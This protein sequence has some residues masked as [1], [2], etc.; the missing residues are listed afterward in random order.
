[1]SLYNQIGIDYDVTRRADPYIVGRLVHHLQTEP[2]GKYLD[3]ACGTGNYTVAIAN[4][5]VDIDGIDQSNLM[6]QT[7]RQKSSQI[8]WH[9]GSAES[10]PFAD[11]T[12]SGALCTLAIHHFSALPPVFREVFRVLESGRFVLFTA[13][14]QQMAGCW[15][16]EYFP[17]ALACSIEQMPDLEPVIHSLQE[18]GFQ[19][20]YTEPY[21]VTNELQDFFFYSGKHRPEIYLDP[22]IR[23]GLSTF[24]S[25]AEPD[26]VDSGCRRLAL[27]IQSGK[28]EDIMRSY[29]HN[30]GD[31]LFIVAEKKPTKA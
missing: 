13:T 1:M 28:I 4:S 18:V 5:G 25:L 30:Q 15:L 9:I 17:K 7:A 3:V 27:D 29:S 6:I 11:R 14:H 21:E 10:L 24:A 20:L 31:Y 2:K 22:R 16:N 12:F 26:E 8:N 23:G 19:L